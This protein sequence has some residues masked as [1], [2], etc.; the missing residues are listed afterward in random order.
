MKYFLLFFCLTFS[1][2]LSAQRPV[3]RPAPAKKPVQ[4]RGRNLSLAPTKIVDGK[5]V[6]RAK[7]T[8]T[9]GTDLLE[10]ESL[11]MMDGATI[12]LSRP[13]TTMII[14]NASIGNDCKISGVG[15]TGKSGANGANGKAVRPGDHRIQSARNQHGQNGQNGRKGGPAK[16]LDLYVETIKYREPLTIILQGGKGGPGGNG[17]QGATKKSD[18][19]RLTVGTNGGN[20]GRGG[21]GGNGT[22]PRYPGKRRQRRIHLQ[23]KMW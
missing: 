19:S 21:S 22:L 6:I 7:Q 1:T 8:Y 9:V 10:L 17:G 14:Q 16:K 5:L 12:R 13:Q 18:C 2:L 23:N 4:T 11:V 15:T 20:G 3:V